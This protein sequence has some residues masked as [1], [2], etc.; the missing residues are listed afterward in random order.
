MKKAIKDIKV[1][2]KI[3]GTDG[4]WHKVIEKT[5]IRLSYNMYEIEFSN[6]FIKCSNTHQWNVFIDNKMYTI[7]AEGIYQEFD[8]Y[9][10]RHVGTIDGPTIIGIKKIE[11]EYVQCIT[12]DAKDHQFAIYTRNKDEL[13]KLS[14]D[15]IHP[16]DNW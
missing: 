15:T 2:D 1:G 4:K 13:E 14:S 12:T 16:T 9:K 7:D 8:W 11:P 10:N 5:N 6:G 3:L